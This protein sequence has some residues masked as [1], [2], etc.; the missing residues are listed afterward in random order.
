M[1]FTKR[2]DFWK[3]S[4]PKLFS[5]IPTN[6]GTT[7]ATPWMASYGCF[8]MELATDL[9]C[10]FRVFSRSILGCWVLQTLGITSVECLFIEL[11]EMRFENHWSTISTYINIHVRVLGSTGWVENTD[12]PLFVDP[13]CFTGYPKVS[14]IGS[15][16]KGEIPEINWKTSGWWFQP[17]NPSKKSW[18]MM[19]VND[20]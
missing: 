17:T 8:L 14:P 1:R 18:L 2:H 10:V 7:L 15:A 5:T 13:R 9:G 6:L 16:W 3:S 20:D 12:L 11:A 4:A 19:M